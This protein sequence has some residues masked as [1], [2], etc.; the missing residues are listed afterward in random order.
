MSHDEDKA[1]LAYRILDDRKRLSLEV[2]DDEGWLDFEF[3]V[4][5]LEPGYGAVRTNG[6]DPV[7][8]TFSQMLQMASLVHGVRLNSLHFPKIAR[9]C[10]DCGQPQHAVDCFMADDDP[11][12]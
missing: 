3:A 7:L 9:P 11:T 12:E 10:S 8:L 2:L 4:S 1:A 5:A 6:D